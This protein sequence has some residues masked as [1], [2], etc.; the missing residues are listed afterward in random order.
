MKHAVKIRDL[1]N[2]GTATAREFEL[3]EC[4]ER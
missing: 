4:N 1:Y 3:I 2:M